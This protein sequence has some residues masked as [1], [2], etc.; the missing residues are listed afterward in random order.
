MF[1]LMSLNCNLTPK[2]SGIESAINKMARF[3]NPLERI[4]GRALHILGTR[5][6]RVTTAKVA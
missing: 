3:Q 1:S 2:F 6:L 4:V 5:C